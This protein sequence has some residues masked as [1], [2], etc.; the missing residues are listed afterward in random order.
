MLFQI[1]VTVVLAL[2]GLQYAFSAIF[3]QRRLE[4]LFSFGHSPFTINPATHP[5]DTRRF[6]NS[7]ASS[8]SSHQNA[9]TSTQ[10]C[11][12]V[13]PN[14]QGPIQVHTTAVV[15]ADLEREL[16]ASVDPGG[17]SHPR[18]CMA[19]ESVALIV[20]YRSRAAHLGIL[21]ANLHPLLQRQQ[22]DYGIYIVEQA[23]SGPFNR[24][25][26]MNI[27]FKEA[28]KVRNYSC[29]IFHDVDLLPEDDRNLY[30]CPEQPRHMSVAIDV[31]KYKLPYA[32]IFGGVS[33]LRR[34]HFERVNGFSN[35]FW[36]WG[37]EDDDMANRIKFH[38]LHISRYP[39]NIAHYKML[40]HKK[41][42]ASPSR[43]K[44]LYS[45]QRRFRTDGLNSLK[46]EVRKKELRPLY[47]WLLVDLGGPPSS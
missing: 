1:V 30:S 19:K 24:A 9:V 36:G 14:L 16:S 37:G 10:Q 2:L 31:F 26:L 41:E 35:A 43:Y 25:M 40:A 46:Y 32:D 45:G 12:L 18:S 39:A 44:N 15:M 11:P 22:M 29:F 42:R 20:P 21:L 8:N 33:A 38:K 28:L 13:P 27:G 4:P 23:G 5:L 7:S 34:D 17:F 47:T 3:E 6:L